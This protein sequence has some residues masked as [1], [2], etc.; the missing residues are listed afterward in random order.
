MLNNGKMMLCIIIYSLSVFASIYLFIPII[1]RLIFWLK[2]WLPK[3]ITSSRS[4]FFKVGSNPRSSKSSLKHCALRWSPDLAASYYQ[5]NFNI[6]HIFVNYS[7]YS[8]PQLDY[9]LFQFLAVHYYLNN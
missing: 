3:L 9:Q 1:L 6:N 7:N 8:H 2:I 4:T 5:L